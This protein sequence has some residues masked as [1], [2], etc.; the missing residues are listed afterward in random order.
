MRAARR[1]RARGRAQR[2]RRRYT[3]R[4][5]DVDGEIFDSTDPAFPRSPGMKGEPFS[6][7][8]RSGAVIP[9]MDRGIRTMREG[10][11]RLLYIPPRLGYGE[12]G[13]KRVPRSTAL[14]F[15]IELIRVQ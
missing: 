7:K 3:G 4:L 1:R 6:W 2:R 5:G 10:G 11:R 13:T 8:Y 14:V 15:D 12:S 9:G